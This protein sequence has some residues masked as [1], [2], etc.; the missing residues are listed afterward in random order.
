MISDAI[1][2]PAKRETVDRD[3]G[4]RA[5]GILIPGWDGMG[6]MKR[7]PCCVSGQLIYSFNAFMREVSQFF[8][9]FVS[10]SAIRS[11]SCSKRSIR[12][13]SPLSL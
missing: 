6:W 2:V 10:Q 12:L 3:L 4:C 8:L 11:A 5:G 7:V 13:S 1:K 9:M